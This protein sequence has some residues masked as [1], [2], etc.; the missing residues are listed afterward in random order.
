ML[1]LIVLSLTGMVLLCKSPLA[2]WNNMGVQPP[3]EKVYAS[4]ELWSHLMAGLGEVD[5]HFPGTKVLEATTDKS[6]GLLKFRLASE[7]RK[8]ADAKTSVKKAHSK[9]EIYTYNVELKTISGVT[10]PVYRSELLRSII[11]YSH[12]IHTGTLYGRWLQ[13]VW[14]IF[15]VLSLLAV[16]S[17]FLYHGISCAST[18]G[19]ITAPQVSPRKFWSDTHRL[20]GVIAGV[21]MLVMAFSGIL[22]PAVADSFVNDLKAHEESA[23]EY[24]AKL[25]AEYGNVSANEMLLPSEALRRLRE[26]FSEKEYRLLAVKFPTKERDFYSFYL[27]E[28]PY[29]PM[30]Y[31]AVELVGMRPDGENIFVVSPSPAVRLLA[32]T[33]QLHRLWSMKGAVRILWG[34]Y[35]LLTL[36]MIISGLL[37][38]IRRHQ[39]DKEIVPSDGKPTAMDRLMLPA[40]FSLTAGLSFLSTMI[41]NSGL[42]AAGLLLLPL[43]TAA[44]RIKTEN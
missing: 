29:G 44:Y 8:S 18:L 1:G 32:G 43:L 39:G 26:K 27:T 19:K 9:E 16:L 34:I 42:L 3:A 40:A 14:F 25:D 41:D 20:T 33:A 24:F 6:R 35:L 22:L 17:G 36:W 21:F 23:A 31:N 12:R 7:Q 37:V 30:R 5:R 2:Q 28:S 10:T 11:K 13:P 15:T 4:D 38:H